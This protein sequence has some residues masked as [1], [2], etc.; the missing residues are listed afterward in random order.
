MIVSRALIQTNCDD[1][2]ETR[3]HCYEVSFTDRVPKEYKGSEADKEG[4]CLEDHSVQVDRY[5]LQ[6]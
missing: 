3:D 2:G 1:S 5:I 4:I 6:C